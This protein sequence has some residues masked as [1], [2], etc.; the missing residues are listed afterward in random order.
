MLQAHYYWCFDA[1]KPIP[2][3]HSWNLKISWHVKDKH[4]KLLVQTPRTTTALAAWVRCQTWTVSTMTLCGC[5]LIQAVVTA[6]QHVENVSRAEAERR[7]QVGVEYTDEERQRREQRVCSHMWWLCLKSYWY[8][9]VLLVAS[10]VLRMYMQCIVTDR[11]A[12][13]VSRDAVCAQG[14]MCCMGVHIS[15]GKRQ[16]WGG[17]GT[18]HCKV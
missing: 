9:C 16:F 14:T 13:S 1:N 7:F 17:N 18:S 15:H 6:L 11:V 8:Q 12:W 4:V 2:I 10:Y 3:A 5:M